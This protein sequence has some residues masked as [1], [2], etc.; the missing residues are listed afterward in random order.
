MARSHFIKPADR[1][2]DFFHRR[3]GLDERW[4]WGIGWV[5]ENDWRAA[6]EHTFLTSMV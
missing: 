3:L 4:S 2:A 6:M 5:D 1:Q